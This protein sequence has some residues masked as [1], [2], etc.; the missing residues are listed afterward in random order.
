MP[1]GTGKT[2]TLTMLRATLS[3]SAERWSDDTIREFQKKGSSSESGKFIVFLSLDK[4][5]ITLDLNLDFENGVASYRTTFGS[6]VQ[7]G[8]R[9]PP[10]LRRFLNKEFVELFVFDGELA[11]R[12][13]DSQET[14][15]REAI[16]QLFQLPLLDQV[17]SALQ[18]NWDEHAK[19][20]SSKQE[21]GLRQRKNRLSA[22][23]KRLEEIARRRKQ[24][25]V[26]IPRLTKAL[27]GLNRKYDDELGTDGRTADELARLALDKV[28]N[29]AD[30]KGM[31]VA[32]ID[33]VR[34]PHALLYDFAA[35]MVTLKQNMDS[36]KLP[37]ST[38]REFF[39]D[40]AKEE[41]CVCGRPLDET[42]RFA[43]R[44]RSLGYLGE[45]ESGVL[46]SMKGD[47]TQHC[48]TD[49]SLAKL[50][51]DDSLAKL[52]EVVF[53][54][55]RIVAERESIEAVRIARGDSA[56]EALK[57]EIGAKQ[58]TLDSL[59]AE[60]AEIES[61]IDG[62]EDD[63]TAK[64]SSL[65]QKKTEAER[66][67]AE[68][69][70]TVVLKRKTDALGTILR[71]AQAGA[72][73]KLKQT[74]VTATN[75]RISQLLLRE[76]LIL[77]NISECLI[78]KNQTGASVGQTLAVS[79]AFLATLFERRDYQ[80]PFVV[81]SPAGPLDLNVR[82]E[83]AKLIPQL[84][85][86]FVAFTISSERDKFVAPLSKACGNDVQYLTLFRSSTAAKKLLKGVCLVVEADAPRPLVSTFKSRGV[87]IHWAGAHSA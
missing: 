72:R 3:G 22:L 14:R 83:V 58:S 66:A 2:T 12:L 69:T 47:I 10:E 57:S 29:D 64:I 15:A 7:K 52:N 51:L 36:L 13:L 30:L 41:I 73:E 32:V 53:E 48:G 82:P 26:Q 43:I 75:T 62:S 33:H 65:E 24:L 28:K 68:A 50:A 11:N 74:L 81:D 55:D 16:D 60:L 61:P 49:I 8:F 34:D 6:G 35:E 27:D 45:E 18:S 37:A 5:R 17:R 84:C 80:L 79:Y 23:T 4:K 67:V 59:V 1:N 78:L 86:Q 70:N 9:P 76:P 54:R 20:V 44:E 31:I 19:T 40:L 38:A 21:K 71:A 46:N 42:T 77:D 39:E 63:E 87:R 56:L 85:Q 25:K